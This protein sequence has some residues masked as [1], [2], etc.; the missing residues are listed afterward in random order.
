VLAAMPLFALRRRVSLK[1]CVR[2]FC[3]RVSSP[4]RSW[5]KK[6]LDLAELTY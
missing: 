1:K 5:T 6:K 2:E 3:E 4:A